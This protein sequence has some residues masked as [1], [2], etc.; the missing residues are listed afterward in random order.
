MASWKY[1]SCI[2]LASCGRHGKRSP[3]L[4][5]SLT[6][7]S[8]QNKGIHST[9]FQLR[10]G[11]CCKMFKDQ[12]SASPQTNKIRHLQ[13]LHT[14]CLLSNNSGRQC[15]FFYPACT[16]HMLRETK[17]DGVR[18]L[19]FAKQKRPTCNSKTKT[20]QYMDPKCFYK[21][22]QPQIRPLCSSLS[23]SNFTRSIK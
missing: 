11:T 9:I 20:V 3:Y 12:S 22:V 8:T 23:R 6:A 10:L 19:K 7:L 21:W 13:C 2:P 18:H 15:V 14:H 4:A 16:A 1:S 5:R 17:S